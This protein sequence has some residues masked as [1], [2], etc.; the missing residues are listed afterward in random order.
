MSEPPHGGD[1]WAVVAVAYDGTE[2]VPLDTYESKR[3]ALQICR[4]N[5]ITKKQSWADYYEIRQT[6]EPI[7]DMDNRA[8]RVRRWFVDNT[9]GVVD[10]EDWR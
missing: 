4:M 7:H 8:A 10:L 6:D 3:K 9:R 1:G 2:S 5:N